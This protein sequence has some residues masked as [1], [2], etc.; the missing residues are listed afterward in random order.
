LHVIFEGSPDIITVPVAYNKWNV[1]NYQIVFEGILKIIEEQNER[2]SSDST[3]NFQSV[4]V[5]SV[6]EGAKLKKEALHFKIDGKNI[7]ELADMDISTLT[8][9]FSNLEDRLSERQRIIAVEIL[10]EIRTRL[11]FLVDVGLT[12]LT[13]NRTAKT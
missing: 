8:E 1:K 13:L 5:C 9:W 11:G 2:K 10:K 12:Y 4:T 7:S 6:C 3:E